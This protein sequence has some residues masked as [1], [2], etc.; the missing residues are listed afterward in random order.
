[1]RAKGFGFP[2]VRVDGNDV[3]ACLAVTRKALQAARDGQGPTLIEAFTYR[4]GAHTTTDDPTRYRLSAELEA[5]KLK[6]PIE[7]V[8]QYLIR[9]GQADMQFFDDIEAEATE[10]GGRVRTACLEMPDPA[11][12]SMFD[13]VLTTETPQLAAERADFAAYLDSFVAEEAVR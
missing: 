7:R 2:G 3:L 8:K 6:D 4:M 10:V 9:S 1:M 13:N 12:T 5:W 11:P